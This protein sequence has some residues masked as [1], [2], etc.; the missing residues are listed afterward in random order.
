MPFFRNRTINLLN[1]HYVI[2]AVA[3]SGGGAFY[4]VYLL[5]AG[6]P[7]PGVLIALAL[8]LL[9]RLVI[10]PVVVPYAI[11]FGLRSTIISGT[12]MS[13]L[14]YPLV[15]EVHGPGPVLAILIA[16]SAVG[17]TFYWTAYHAYFATLGDDALRG[18]QIGVREAMATLAAIASPLVAA[19][20]LVAF[21]PRAAFGPTGI[22]RF[23]AA[24]PLLW[25]PDVSVPPHA[26]GSYKATA[27]G[28]LLFIAD[29]WI[30]ACSVMIWQIALF[31]SLRESVVG[32][33]GAMAFAALA[34][35]VAALTLGRHIDTGHGRRA[36]WYATGTVAL[37]IALR[38]AATG[39][40]SLAVLANALGAFG[41]SLYIPTMMTPV[42]TM[43]KGSPCVLR[44][45]TATEA[46]WDIG[47]AAA[48]SAGALATWFGAPLPAVIL[49]ALAGV[50]A[51]AALLRRYYAGRAPGVAAASA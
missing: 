39:H 17:E 34:S 35:A 26:P 1:L 33:G 28:F 3:V 15:A 32:Y 31:L 37:I 11:R 44:F 9:G 21:G 5:K 45:H 43:A 30:A 47:G 6:V 18:H 51:T 36:I 46:G 23:C 24:L 19:W 50:A 49:L 7:I 40:P 8:I 20:L 12:V 14:Q 22:I 16:V 41:A 42:Y 13:A 10:R 4:A 48:L 25:A 27:L 29:G 38:A 2:Q